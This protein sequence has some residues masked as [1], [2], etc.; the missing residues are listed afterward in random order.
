MRE[1]VTPMTLLDRLIV[2]AVAGG[3]AYAGIW[4]FNPL[5]VPAS[6]E[7]GFALAVG[8]FFAVFGGSANDFF[9]EVLDWIDFFGWFHDRRR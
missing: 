1:P 9:I 3:L 4:F 2:G 8:L 5:E 6:V 7:I